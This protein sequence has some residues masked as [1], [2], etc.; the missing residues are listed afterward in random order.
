MG[1]SDTGTIIDLA[2]VHT[3]RIGVEWD[4][5]HHRETIAIEHLEPV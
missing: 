1:H 5:D 3:G 4:E 2:V